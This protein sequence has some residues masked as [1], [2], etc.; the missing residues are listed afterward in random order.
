MAS[1][2]RVLLPGLC[3]FCVQCSASQA[4]SRG[5]LTGPPGA[6]GAGEM[7]PAAL[8]TRP[9]RA[10]P[11]EVT[12]ATTLTDPQ[13][14]AVLGAIVESEIAQA[15]LGEGRAVND[16]VID[17]AGSIITRR[18]ATQRDLARFM[19]MLPRGLERSEVLA[20]VQQ[21]AD[22]VTG[23]MAGADFDIAYLTGQ[24]HE[25][26]RDIAILDTRLVPDAE[27]RE[28]ERIAKAL[29]KDIVAELASA[30]ALRRELVD[31]AGR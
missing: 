29:R 6:A 3:M 15:H 28:L 9:Q 19:S 30:R 11:L 22:R 27:R 2:L 31:G 14:A 8:V 7:R 26:Q 17:F 12:T 20:R 1:V 10:G 13:I 18:S 16:G 5:P 4:P 25:F 23:S 21:D 24:I